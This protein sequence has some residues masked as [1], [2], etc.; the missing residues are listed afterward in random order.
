MFAAYPVRVRVRVRVRVWSSGFFF[1]V[2]V[3]F[4][5][6]GFVFSL[7]LVIRS[8]LGSCC[9]GSFFGSYL[10]ENGFGIESSL[11]RIQFNITKIDLL[12]FH[13][14]ISVVLYYFCIELVYFLISHIKRSFERNIGRTDIFEI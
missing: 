7:S 13:F 6:S 4:V 11:I 3:W 1:L 14:Y 12:V 2:R 9:L 10:N 8:C 5:L